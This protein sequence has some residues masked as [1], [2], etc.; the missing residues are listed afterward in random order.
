MIW[1][2]GP[3][4]GNLTSEISGRKKENSRM[5][6]FEFDHGFCRLLE[7]T[8]C[9]PDKIRLVEGDFL[10]TFRENQ[11]DSPDVICGN[12]PYSVGS[13]IIMDILK[14]SLKPDRMV[15]ML[16]KEV[17]K[18][19]TAEPGSSEYSAFSAHCRLHWEPKMLF[20]VNR[21]SFYPEPNVSS[22][23]VLFLPGREKEFKWKND[24]F[25]LVDDLFAA[26]RKTI[27]NN[28]K[29]AKITAKYGS[30]KIEEALEKSSI[31]PG[32]RAERLNASDFRTI[33]ENL[34][35]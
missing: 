3:G 7:K 13:V 30:E 28:L 6:L 31:D 35:N 1:E 29:N 11:N 25:M 27:R 10:K 19:I 34:H 2:I 15:F 14:S 26:R 17:V 33:T 22:A 20:A 8:I 9:S 16:Q 5:T 32:L 12:L 23:V 4:I 18:R 21:G 24:Y